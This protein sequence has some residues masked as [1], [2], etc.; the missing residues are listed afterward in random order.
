MFSSIDKYDLFAIIV[1]IIW[2]MVSIIGQFHDKRVEFIRKYDIFGLIPLWTF[3]APNP[4]HTDYHLLYR[5]KYNNDSST[6]TP[7]KEIPLTTKRRKLDFLWNPSKRKTKVMSDAVHYLLNF[8]EINLELKIPIK[9]IKSVIMVSTPYLI[10][11]SIV[12][13]QGK[14]EKKLIISR[15]FALA[16]SFG[17][18]S[19]QKPNLI[20]C[21]AFHHLKSNKSTRISKNV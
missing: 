3:F 1:L 5:D 21:S 12:A 19:N 13:S 8:I 7:W 15:Q 6:I 9:I 20:L 18:N 10:L 11:L 4:G 14:K 2:F 17:F 16:E